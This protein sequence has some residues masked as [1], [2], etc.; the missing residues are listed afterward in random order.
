M[1]S[2]IQ[3]V[4]TSLW[5]RYD[6]TSAKATAHKYCHYAEVKNNG[7][8]CV[9]LLDRGN[10]IFHFISKIAGIFSSWWNLTKWSWFVQIY[11]RIELDKWKWQ[12]LSNRSS[13][14]LC[15]LCKICYFILETW[16]DGVKFVPKVF[17]YFT[18]IAPRVHSISFNVFNWILIFLLLWLFAF[19]IDHQIGIFWSFNNNISYLLWSF[20]FVDFHV[21]LK[22]LLYNI[23]NWHVIHLLRG[24]NFSIWDK[25]FSFLIISLH[26]A[27]SRWT[28]RML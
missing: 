3:F 10:T 5:N 28:R 25:Q 2:W 16:L 17:F 22:P 14:R 18:H 4:T 24:L 20:D 19:N 21:F 27:I 26:K 8:M 15:Y 9:H 23:R 7:T 11:L 12:L 1:F 13:F 6:K